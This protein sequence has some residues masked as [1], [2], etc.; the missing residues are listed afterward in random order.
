MKTT[1]FNI[2]LAVIITTSSFMLG[3]METKNEIPTQQQ[4]SQD[5]NLEEQP[6]NTVTYTRATIINGE[7]LPVVDLPELTISADGPE[8]NIVHATI[9]DGEVIPYVNLPEVKIEA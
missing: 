9:L 4:V 7:M 8:Q 3:R 6:S 5:I 2:S 1:I